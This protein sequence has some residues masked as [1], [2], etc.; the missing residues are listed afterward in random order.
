MPINPIPINKNEEREKNTES[1]KN[2]DTKRKADIEFILSEPMYT[3]DD[4]IL[5][6]AVYGEIT[7]AISIF[8]YR[9]KLFDEWKLSRV[10]K[11]P[12]NLAIN[13]YGESGTG[14]TMAAN[15]IANELGFKVLK[16][17][18]ADI[19]SKYVGETSKNL[20]KLFETTR[21]DTLILFDEADAL[22]SR[23]VTDMS[24]ATDVSVNQT[25]SVLLTLLDGFKGVVVFTTNFISN[26]D[27]A[28]MRRIPYHIRFELPN[29]ALRERLLRHYLTDTVPNNIAIEEV[30]DKF[31]G[32]TGCDIANATM[33]AALKNAVKGSEVLSQGDFEN[34]LKRIVNS[35]NANLHDNV[36]IE[37]REVSEEYALSQIKKGGEII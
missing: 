4:M 34:A 32:I 17:N 16:V 14:K 27:P 37:Q 7:D 24:S 21:D 25:R 6:E 36:T 28:F 22:L 20:T 10:I 13:L 1:N 15:A 9:D 29:K 26:Y 8:K 35:K 23:R 3:F 33:S 12:A 31:D 30:A 2:K 19:E 11:K 5:D 18:Y